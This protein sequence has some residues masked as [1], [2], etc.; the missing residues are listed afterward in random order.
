MSSPARRTVPLRGLTR[1]MPARSRVLLPA[2]LCPSRAATPP[3]GTVS[4]M[5]CSTTLLPY[6]TC[7]ESNS[8]MDAPQVDLLDLRVGLHLGDGPLTED[9]PGVHDRH[10]TGEAAQEVHVVLDHDDGA[11]GADDP[12]Q[13]PGGV[14]LLLAHP[15]H[16]LGEQQ[17]PH[18]P[19]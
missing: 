16:R 17:H 15:R 5:P 14:A 19:Y 10:R 7:T 3:A 6:P 13:F 4:E 18:A 8:S 1:P 12:E 9:L 2:P 11:V